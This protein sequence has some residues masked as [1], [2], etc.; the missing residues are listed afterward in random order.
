MKKYYIILLILFTSPIYSQNNQ[1]DFK[2]VITH[3]KTAE[4]S[5][6]IEHFDT[7]GYFN[8]IFLSD[9]QKDSIKRSISEKDYTKQ[10]LFEVHYGNNFNKVQDVWISK[11]PIYFELNNIVIENPYI[12]EIK[13]KKNVPEFNYDDTYPLS[14][15]VIYNEYIITLF[16][17]GKFTCVST[18]DFKRNKELENKLN[19]RKFQYHWL[20]NGKLVAKS[21][22]KILYWDGNDWKKYKSKLVLNKQPK[23]FEN[24]DFLVF[25]DCFGEFGGLVY[26][27]N[28]STSKVHYTES[29]CT[30]R[31]FKENGRYYIL[32]NLGH[33]TGSTALKSISDPN[34][35]PII[36]KSKLNKRRK[37]KKCNC[38]SSS[39][40]LK[41]EF[42]YS[43]FQIF[44]S[45]SY[46]N[47][48]LYIAH[49]RGRA[50]LVEFEKD[51]ISIVNPLFDNVLFSHNPVTNKYDNLILINMSYYGIAGER[52]VGLILIR[53][54]QITRIRWN[55]YRR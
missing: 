2:K 38:E 49:M 13:G 45:F 10:K 46:N 5:D 18:K 1:V 9:H 55:N 54:N 3:F 29:T 30:V 15:S 35:L 12:N 19:S 26:F 43:G 48:V 4:Y 20:I 21:K 27:Y 34:E 7:E 37:R 33:M 53:D 32:E 6:V 52:E 16:E 24:K 14:Y 11:N 25:S 8:N 39:N 17:P 41:I 22:N 42:D 50:L 23:L 51:K 47:R 28:K 40:N 36:S 31:V 44:S